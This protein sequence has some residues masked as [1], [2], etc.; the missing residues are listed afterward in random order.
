MTIQISVLEMTA[1]KILGIFEVEAVPRIGENIR[2]M[3]LDSEGT[4]VTDYR[5]V[6][7]EW[8]VAKTAKDDCFTFL[9]AECRVKVHLEKELNIGRPVVLKG[10]EGVFKDE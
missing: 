4:D 3:D 7:I 1:K 2:I 5:V 10:K 6:D 9:V 8:L